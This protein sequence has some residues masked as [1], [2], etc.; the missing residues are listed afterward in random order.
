VGKGKMKKL[1]LVFSAFIVALMV[2]TINMNIFL[3]TA[4]ASGPRPTEPHTPDLRPSHPHIRA[5]K[6]KTVTGEVLSL[7]WAGYAVSSSS[8][9]VTDVKGSWIVPSLSCSRTT[10]YAAFWVGIDGYSDNTVEQTGVLAECYQGTAY[11]YTWYEFYPA[12]P[13]YVTSTVPVSA[14]NVVYGEVSYS[15]SLFTVTL[16]DETTSKTFTK[17]LSDSSALRS[18]AEWIAEAPSSGAQILPLATFGTVSYGLDYTKL[19]SPLTNYAT[20]KSVTGTI[21][22]FKSA[23]EELE[24]VTSSLVVKAAPSALTADGESFQVTWKHS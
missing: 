14:G 10:A 20:V 7:N 12:A 4:A 17:A 1:V 13:V 11:Y 19:T 24:M 22:S 23:V 16:T 2:L 21:G 15:S 18:S 6:T 5:S 3:T 9:S 8:G